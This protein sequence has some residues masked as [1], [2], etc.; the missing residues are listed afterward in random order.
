MTGGV[1]ADDIADV[2]G[3][4][5]DADEVISRLGHLAASMNSIADV[6]GAVEGG[7][8]SQPGKLKVMDS[9]TQSSELL[10]SGDSA[11][12]VDPAP[13]RADAALLLSL[14]AHHLSL[15]AVPG[16]DPDA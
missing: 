14:S 10:S 15:T 13:G 3:L 1:D 2:V 11:T 12:T 4:V 16:R 6:L 7:L 9:I 8:E 5:V